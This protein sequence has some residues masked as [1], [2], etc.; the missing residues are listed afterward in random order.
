MSRSRILNGPQGTA[1]N[2]QFL[3]AVAAYER[4]HAPLATTVAVSQADRARAEAPAPRMSS[5]AVPCPQC[6]RALEHDIEHRIG[7]TLEV[8]RP[9][10]I[11]RRLI[12]RVAEP[13]PEVVRPRAH[14]T[15]RKAKRPNGAA[16][17]DV[18]AVLPVG[19]SNAIGAA[20]LSTTFG[21]PIAT[22]NTTLRRLEARGQVKRAQ[23]ARPITGNGKRTEWRYW[24]AA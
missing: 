22:I 23:F 20:M 7:Y 13:E 4:E 12:A 11:R 8:C 18:L 1:L 24:K 17:K 5:R 2:H 19:K 15:D 14:K 6:G 9:C 16:I 21:Y 10:G 3:Q